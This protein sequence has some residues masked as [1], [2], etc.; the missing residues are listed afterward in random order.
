MK[1]LVLLLLFG[2]SSCELLAATRYIQKT[3]SNDG[4][5]CTQAAPCL[6]IG[7]GIAT[8]SGGDT[9]LIG[10]GTYNESV[11][12][13]TGSI[14]AGSSG[15]PTIVRAVNRNQAIVQPT[16]SA[17]GGYLVGF[18]ISNS[19]ITIDGIY[20]DCS[21]RSTSTCGAFETNQYATLTNLTIEHSTS[22]ETGGGSGGPTE[23]SGMDIHN[24]SSGCLLFD[25]DITGEGVH[26]N[27]AYEH[28]LYLNSGVIA[29]GNRITTAAGYGIQVY[30]GGALVTN[31][32][33]RNNT[34]TGGD[35]AGIIISNTGT[36]I[37][38]YNNV[39]SGNAGAG[40]WLYGTNGAVKLYNN[41]IYNN[42]NYCITVASGAVNAEAKNNICR[43][44]TSGAISDSGTTTACSNN[45]NVTA[46]G[47]TQGTTDP[48][49]VN[50]GGGNFHLTSMSPA[51]GNATPLL[52][53]FTTD[54]D[55]VVRGSVWDQGA[56][57][58]VT[59]GAP[60]PSKT[61]FRTLV[62]R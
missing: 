47:T 53:V 19:Y 1:S 22:N 57:E 20:V 11:G 36:G 29:D 14:P 58:F 46:C 44:N 26:G 35:Y 28:G 45:L 40:I 50:A 16:P 54:F 10:N 62:V 2:I 48:L 25:N 7:R 49:F 38:A 13:S 24:C 41:T 4:N 43:S 18:Y 31:V 61:I 60:F 32:T 15:N 33:L 34:V 59:S 9:L 6:T 56:F 37:L 21:Q 51:I 8:M 12:W 42:G 17:P 5:P 23:R 39:V 3:G 27:A 30:D 55:N 52:S